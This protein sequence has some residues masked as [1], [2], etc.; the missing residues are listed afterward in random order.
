MGDMEAKTGKSILTSA[1][2]TGAAL[3]WN[4]R[5]M[6]ANGKVVLALIGGQNQGWKDT[7]NAIKGGAEFKTFCDIDQAILD[8]YNPV[9]EKAQGKKP[10]T[11]KD[12][13]KVL[14]D[15]EIDGVIIA[16][17]D[18]WHARIALLALQA[19]K[20]IYL[21]KPMTHTIHEGHVLREA[22]R[23]YNKR[24]IQIG[25]QNRS[26]LKFLHGMEFLKTGKL[27]KICEISVWDCQVRPSV[28]NPPDGTPPSTVD[29]DVWL[30]PAPKR[31]FNKNRFH[32]S[33]RFFWDYGNSELGNL[34][35]HL[36]DVV[37]WGIQ[38]MRGNIHDCL[39]TRVSG[40]SKIYWLK[41]AK[42][43]PDTQRLAFD[44]GDF[45][46]SWQLRSFARHHPINGAPEG[47]CF[48]GT[49][50]VL[51]FSYKD[52]KVYYKDKTEGPGEF[53]GDERENGAHE[54]NFIEC[55]K[56]RQQPNSTLE[57]GRLA[58]TFCHIGNVCTRL[59]RDVIF[60]PKTETFGNDKAA[61][62]YLTKVYRK[63]YDLPKV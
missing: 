43:I 56:S 52:W 12:F 25:T 13:M 11:T 35:V 36:L 1:L 2:A 4:P 62:A 46:V 3:N 59:G 55:I 41:D 24:V 29:Y 5:A 57:L 34:G 7:L 9:F 22:A 44:F 63:P 37:Q 49:E 58:T 48:V 23:K 32:Y 8:K 51:Q 17:P 14:D 30:G 33:W 53:I 45:L 10:E 19:G 54:K 38:T 61:N 31:P 60:D 6:G 28:G 21:E 18:H 50:G 27:G 20:D 26:A 47:I 16:V 40:N 39:P 42:E 15:K